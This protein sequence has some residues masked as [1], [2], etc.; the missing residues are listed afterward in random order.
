MDLAAIELKKK[1]KKS[2]QHN[3]MTWILCLAAWLYDVQSFTAKL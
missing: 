2:W 3:S 1:K